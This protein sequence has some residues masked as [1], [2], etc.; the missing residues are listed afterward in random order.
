MPGVTVTAKSP[1]TGVLRTVV[2]NA[3]GSLRPAAAATGFRKS[4]F[5][6]VRFGVV[7]QPIRITVGSSLT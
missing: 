5:R 6:T 4:P 1:N 7:T 3:E 2:T